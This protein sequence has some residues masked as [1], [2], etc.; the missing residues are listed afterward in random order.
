[1]EMEEVKQKITENR[2]LGLDS[3]FL[4]LMEE[5]RRSLI[6]PLTDMKFL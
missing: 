1:M 3:F 4:R 2:S 5:R 6:N